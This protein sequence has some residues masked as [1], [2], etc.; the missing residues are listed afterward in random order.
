MTMTA[1]P[2]LLIIGNRVLKDSTTR[3]LWLNKLLVF[4]QPHLLSVDLHWVVTEK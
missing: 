3:V 4:Q 1:G 2:P